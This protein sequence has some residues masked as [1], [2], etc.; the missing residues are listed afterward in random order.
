MSDH[1]SS[2]NG[3]EVV[4]QS[5]GN[6]GIEVQVLK[7]YGCGLDVHSRFIAVCVHVRNNN[8]VFKYMSDFD[9]DW[10]SL[11]AA[12]EWVIDIIRKYSD[13]IPDLD[14]PLHYVLEATSTYHMPVLRAWGG[15][16]SIINPMIAG[17][18][19]KKTD[20]LDAERLSFH[21]LTGVWPKSFVASDD[22]SELRVLIAE[23]NRYSRL[24][25]QCSNR[26]NNILVRFGITIGRGTSVTI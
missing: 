22:L 14:L 23:R 16:P 11:A 15:I 1:I 6:Q 5:E 13:P 18:T 9:T 7:S 20:D 24:A 3:V 19:Q 17:A 2:N 26:I 21:D 4:I 10:N 8:R 25:T 12:R